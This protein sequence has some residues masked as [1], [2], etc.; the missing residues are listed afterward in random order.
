VGIN[1]GGGEETRKNKEMK[2]IE[3]GTAKKVDCVFK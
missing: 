1:K 3:N 2:E